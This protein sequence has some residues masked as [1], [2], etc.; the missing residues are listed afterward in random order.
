MALIA[1]HKIQ[2]GAMSTAYNLW[3]KKTTLMLHS[4]NITDLATF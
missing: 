4:G 2:E 3:K 1:Y